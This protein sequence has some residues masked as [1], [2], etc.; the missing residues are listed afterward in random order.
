MTMCCNWV[1]A[2]TA[3]QLVK[4]LARGDDGD[5]AAGVAH[6]LGDL[7]AGE[8]GIKRHI[9]GADGQRGEIGYGPLPAVLADEDDAVA[10][11]APKAQKRRGQSPDSL[12]NLVRGDGVPVAEFVLP[13]DGA[14]IGGRG[15]AKEEV[16]DRG[17]RRKA[18]LNRL[19][20][21]GQS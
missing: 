14:R 18:S 10:L 13:K 11:L 6:Q 4:L 3:L 20:N 16:I 21:R 7:L 5:A 8:R 17:D 2:R 15:D 9:G 12:I 19:W 1:C